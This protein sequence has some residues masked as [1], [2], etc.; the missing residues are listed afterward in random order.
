MPKRRA[1]G[2]HSRCYAAS[3]LTTPSQLRFEKVVRETGTAA[4]RFVLDGMNCWV[5]V[6]INGVEEEATN[7]IWIWDPGGDGGAVTGYWREPRK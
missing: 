1:P 4:C 5:L 7:E 3:S 2:I 6:K